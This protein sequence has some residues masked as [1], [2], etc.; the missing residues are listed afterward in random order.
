MMTLCGASWILS[1]LGDGHWLHV[2]DM[3]HWHRPD[4]AEAEADAGNAGDLD[5]DSD[6]EGKHESDEVA[7]C[8]RRWRTGK[9]SRRRLRKAS[10][11]LG[12]TLQERRRE[13]T[14]CWLYV[15]CIKK[16]ERKHR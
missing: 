3:L 15:T 6:T 4:I 16:K 8:G 1:H 9:V 13:A 10:G 12:R 5:M 11:L 7:R 14:V 2:C